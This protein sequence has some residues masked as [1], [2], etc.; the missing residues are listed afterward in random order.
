MLSFRPCEPKSKGNLPLKPF[1][2]PLSKKPRS[3]T[4]SALRS[5]LNQLTL[6]FVINSSTYDTDTIRI[7]LAGSLLTGDA[8]RWFSPLLEATP[9]VLTKTWADAH[10]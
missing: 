3:A 8:L 2:P 5:F 7:G 1:Q 10:Q 6:I 4:R 9:S